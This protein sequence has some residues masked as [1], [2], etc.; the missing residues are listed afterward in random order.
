MK[1]YHPEPLKTQFLSQ[2]ITRNEKGPAVKKGPF[3][4][5]VGAREET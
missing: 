2:E 3:K 1:Q 5:Y 4:I